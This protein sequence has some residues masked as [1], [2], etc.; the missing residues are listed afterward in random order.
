MIKFDIPLRYFDVIEV[1]AEDQRVPFRLFPVT[2]TRREAAAV[3]LA[4]T[5]LSAKQ[6]GV[7]NRDHSHEFQRSENPSEALLRSLVVIFEGL[8]FSMRLA[9]QG[10]G[11]VISDWLRAS[12]AAFQVL[13]LTPEGYWQS[14]DKDP[15]YAIRGPAA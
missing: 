11:A 13:K 8:C 2:G 1:V 7:P 6:P 9:A 14:F 3:H 15:A 5:K 10:G 4:R 12:R